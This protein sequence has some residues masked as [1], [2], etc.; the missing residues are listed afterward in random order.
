MKFYIIGYNPSTNSAVVAQL[1][2]DLTLTKREIPVPTVKKLVDSG[3][4]YLSNNISNIDTLL[5]S[6]SNIEVNDR[7]S[8]RFVC[9]CRLS[10]EK[11]FPG[12]LYF[13]CDKNG[14]QYA[15]DHSEFIRAK[16]AIVGYPENPSEFVKG[17]PVWRGVKTWKADDD[18]SYKYRCSKWTKGDFKE[19][20]SFDELEPLIN[21]G[22]V[23]EE[24]VSLGG[25]NAE[26]SLDSK[27][28]INVTEDKPE[29]NLGKTAN[30]AETTKR[31]LPLAG[32][33]EEDR[34]FKAFDIIDNIKSYNELEKNFAA[35]VAKTILRNNQASD[36]QLYWLE[37]MQEELSKTG[38]LKLR[39]T[40]AEK[41]YNKAKELIRELEKYTDFNDS[42]IKDIADNIMSKQSA[43]SVEIYKLRVA[44]DKF[45]ENGTKK[46]SIVESK[47]EVVSVESKVDV[48]KTQNLAGDTQKSSVGS[49]ESQLGSNATT[50]EVA[51]GD[52]S[53]SIG[54]TQN[55]P[56]FLERRGT[57]TNASRKASDRI[58]A[59]ER[60]E[61]KADREAL[62]KATSDARYRAFERKRIRARSQ[63]I[64]TDGMFDYSLNQDGTA[65][66]EG[67]AEHQ[68]ED[69]VH[70]PRSV[71]HNGRVY[72]VTGISKEAFLNEPIREFY[73]TDLLS[74]I[75]QA[76]FSHCK[77]LKIIDLS[78]SR[79]AFIASDLCFACENLEDVQVGSRIQRIHDHA[80]AYCISLKSITLPSTCTE[81]ARYAFAKCYKL[82]SVDA[83][84][85][86][87][88][89]GAFIGC[90][91]LKRFNFNSVRAIASHCFR[92]T[93][94][95]EI[96]LPGG[97]G[98]IG[99]KA[100]ADCG[101]LQKVTI[102]E[103]VR[104]IGAFCFA[105]HYLKAYD[106]GKIPPYEVA[107]INEIFT[108]K[109]L[110]LIGADA[111]RNACEVVVWTG[112]LAESKCIAFN[113]FYRTRDNVN[114]NNSSDMRIKAKIVGSNPIESLY[115][116]ISDTVEG[117]SNPKDYSINTDK[118][119]SVP[120]TEGHFQFFKIELPG[121][122]VEPHVLYKAAVNYLQRV[123]D[124]YSTPLTDRV[125]RMQDAFKVVTKM[126]FDDGYNRICKIS[127]QIK[128]TL[129][130]GE[131][132]AVFEGMTLRFVAESNLYTN[133][134]ISKDL[135]NDQDLPIKQYLHAGDILG[136]ASTIS[137]ES[138][139]IV[140]DGCKRPVGLKFYNK[141]CQNAIV[142]PI[143][144]KDEYVYVPS[145]NLV[146]NLHTKTKEEDNFGREIKD[147]SKAVVEILDYEKF[148]QDVLAI[149]KNVGGYSG[150]FNS[151]VRMTDREVAMRTEGIDI[152]Q[153]AVPNDLFS[154]SNSFRQSVGNTIPNPTMLSLQDFS[155][156][157]KSYW[158]V[159]RDLDWLQMVGV[160]SLNRTGEYPLLDVGFKIV[161]FQSNQIVKFSNPYMNGC[162][163]AYIFVLYGAG[164]MVVG[165]YA[166][167]MRLETIV[168]KL[169]KLTQLTRDLA[170]EAKV[171]QVMKDPE[172]F[173]GYDP[174]Y[175]YSFYD[176]LYSKKGWTFADLFKGFRAY[177]SMST[178]F[179]FNISMF[180]PTGVFYLTL[181][182]VDTSDKE[183]MRYR[184]FPI[185]P[186]GNM[187]RAL[188]VATTTNTSG[189]HEKLLKELM[190]IAYCLNRNSPRDSRYDFS[191]VYN[192]YI[193]ARKMALDGVSSVSEYLKYID[194]RAAY[195]IG[196]VQR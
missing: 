169:Y 13:L 145:V 31:E 66:V 63:E 50:D 127:Y 76:A 114:R 156:L 105:K 53:S 188:M 176:V 173:E 26:V 29:D 24:N 97:I 139:E 56:S 138:T 40:E 20:R 162:K 133:I 158:I 38:R 98:T 77:H 18:A 93:G 100:F 12:K 142:L 21:S 83:H 95:E 121:E 57:S 73:G 75:G 135:V 42:V 64:I 129:N 182:K 111:F 131:Y 171:I 115:R 62:T 51:E 177:R 190:S 140:V 193:K 122:P 165:A 5:N 28:N 175:F 69:V 99:E 128:D 157:S 187:D 179:E 34:L 87:I 112:S 164:N 154:L 194:D 59:D 124:M 107:A 180:K 191:D 144:K 54:D 48:V 79:L 7:A 10:S 132:I 168:E 52:T 68:L 160:K 36:K 25:S 11:V 94:F 88:D 186:I 74:D 16:E 195:M 6:V 23:P 118:L 123:S 9:F 151:I 147:L 148:I 189:K 39:D 84:I 103:G 71:T 130:T 149:K 116:R 41:R 163:G 3:E 170:E 19:K 67:F 58:E 78:K 33:Q 44:L 15:I 166:S 120:L 125:L 161:E 192:N 91:K 92:N 65:Y 27:D 46:G 82:Q 80:F 152:V 104:E 109:S 174:H 178:G 167:R 184:V 108:P 113:T 17:L 185:I 60:K 1:K 146:L 72:G 159:P 85:V 155:R 47:P 172:V 45:R 35:K 14:K 196:T 55:K 81:V 141:I 137:G 30:S 32:S 8:N 183:K 2:E 181:A 110:T 96:V 106:Y 126:L 22:V 119:V 86:D 143:T 43:S 37:K 4:L 90:K 150:F 89:Y 134:D 101:R 153:P 136:I 102:E 70:L 49:T 61:D 117:I